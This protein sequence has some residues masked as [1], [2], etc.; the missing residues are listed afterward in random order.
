VYSRSGVVLCKTRETL[1]S[2]PERFREKCQ[3]QLEIGTGE[4]GSTRSLKG[5]INGIQHS[6]CGS[7]DSPSPLRGEG[8]GEGEMPEIGY[9]VTLSPTPLPSRERGFSRSP[10]LRILYVGRLVYLKG[11]HLA[12]PAFAHLYKQNPDARLT[13]VGSGPEE[14][15]LKRLASDLGIDH[16][17]EWR[18]WLTQR[19]V[20]QVYPQ[21]DV[22][23]FPSLHDSSGNAVLE[24]LSFGLPV[25][26]LNLGGP[27]V[28]VDDSCGFRV[29]GPDEQSVINELG[30]SMITLAEDEPLR[31]KMSISAFARANEHFSWSK[32]TERMC[33]IY[34]S[35]ERIST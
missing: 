23:L 19:E 28:L 21:H 7:S 29:S 31:R 1:N 9:A 33:G 14:Q 12:L 6:D 35:L 4:L 15:R 22:F 16:A 27:G 30:R 24:A 17:I 5:P 8:R 32:Q 2:I 20:M 10:S 34:T 26:C 18:S 25:V 11:V 13:I 3:L